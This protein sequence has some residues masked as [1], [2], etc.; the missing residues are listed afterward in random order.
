VHEAVLTG[1]RYDGGAAQAA[2]IV[3]ATAA[4]PDL[5][6][7][8]IELAQPYTGK[9]G[10]VLATLKAQLYGAVVSALST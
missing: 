6:V 8:A 2:G 3:H 1:R 5:V 7:R 10:A 4:Q 9:Q